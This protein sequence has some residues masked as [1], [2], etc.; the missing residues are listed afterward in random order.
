MHYLDHSYLT[1]KKFKLDL[2]R[3]TEF[4]QI[5]S[6]IDSSKK[7]HWHASHRMLLHTIDYGQFLT[8]R[9]FGELVSDIPTNEI[10]IAHIEDDFTN[11]KPRLIDWIK[12][13]DV[14]KLE[15]KIEH[16][17][18]HFDRLPNKYR[19]F[20]LK[21]FNMTKENVSMLIP[22]SLFGAEHYSDSEIERAEYINTL[23]D[24]GLIF[25]IKEVLECIK[26]D[27]Q[28]MNNP[29]KEKIKWIKSLLQMKK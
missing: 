6:F 1:C 26:F 8:K 2:N 9:K 19:D 3:N 14:S 16:L 29:D 28:W 20:I 5:H 4:D 15:D 23:D 22:C 7:Y 24:Y 21:P 27:E 12:K 17:I 18:S 11:Y 10:L 25:D 13:V